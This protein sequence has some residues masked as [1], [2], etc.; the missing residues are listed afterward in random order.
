MIKFTGGWETNSH[1]LSLCLRHA[2]FHRKR[3]NAFTWE[4]S[5]RRILY[6]A[7]AIRGFLAL[8]KS[9]FQELFVASVPKD[10]SPLKLRITSVA[11][12][13]LILRRHSGITVPGASRRYIPG[14][15][16]LAF[17]RD[18]FTQSVLVIF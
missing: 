2:I 7:S 13:V 11:E 18:S 10:L 17:G 6:R 14:T 8:K 16:R 1:K 3:E 12:S 15:Q 5:L 9:A 4:N